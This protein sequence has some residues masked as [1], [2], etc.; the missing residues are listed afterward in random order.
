MRTDI[1]QEVTD[2][3]VAQLETANLGEWKQPW[4]QNRPQNIQ[5]R[6]YT[7]IN[8]FLLG[9][10]SADYPSQTYATYKA[11]QGRG[12]Q[13]SRGQ[14]G[15][16]I[17]FYKEYRG[18]P[19]TTD[20]ASAV[21]DDGKVSRRVARGYTVFAAEQCEGEA[22]VEIATASPQNPNVAESLASVDKLTTDYSAGESITIKTEGD[23]AYYV[24]KTD[25]VVLP[26]MS[27]FASTEAYYST[28]LHEIT[29]STGTASRCNRDK[30]NNRFGTEAYAY[31]ELVAEIGSA[32]LCATL[33]VEDSPREDHAQYVANWLQVI[34]GNKR[35]V[36]NAAAAAQ[37]AANYVLKY[38][39]EEGSPQ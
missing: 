2:K 28:L 32:M 39:V 37:R 23:R 10:A 16:H 29:H 4:I 33:G 18:A 12:A 27:A 9:L 5:G 36:F 19:G 26:P 15:T 25:T 22:A 20:S 13:V 17:I 35:A 6:H 7:G 24:P 11:W 3:I 31:E 1:Y 38:R 14:R 34:K 30:A 21:G 8:W